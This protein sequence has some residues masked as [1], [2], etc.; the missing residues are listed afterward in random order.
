MSPNVE[1]WGS[2]I[3]LRQPISGAILLLPK[4]QNHHAIPLLDPLGFGYI[5]QALETAEIGMV[6]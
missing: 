3:V 6:R 4:G 2:G 5:K 1:I